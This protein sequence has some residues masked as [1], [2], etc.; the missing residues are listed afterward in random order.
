MLL[1]LDHGAASSLRHTSDNLLDST[2]ANMVKAEYLDAVILA[3]ECDTDALPCFASY[4]VAMEVGM[5][6][7]LATAVFQHG[8]VDCPV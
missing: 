4:G 2:G 7:I 6:A 5:L 3:A 1:R 8:H